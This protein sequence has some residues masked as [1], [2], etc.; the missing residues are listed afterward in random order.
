MI[1]DALNGV[2]WWRLISRG[3]PHEGTTSFNG[4]H[5]INFF[6]KRHTFMKH[7][8]MPPYFLSLGSMF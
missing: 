5:S 4:I 7:E 8:S 3:P 2:G 6:L 1:G